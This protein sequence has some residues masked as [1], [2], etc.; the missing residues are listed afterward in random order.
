MGGF[1]CSLE[2]VSQHMGAY[3]RVEEGYDVEGEVEGSQ[4]VAWSVDRVGEIIGEGDY[5]HRRRDYEDGC[6]F[7]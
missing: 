1:T 3:D 2:E 5:D 4:S 6:I 7:D